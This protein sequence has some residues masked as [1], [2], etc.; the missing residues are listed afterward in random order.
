M[1]MLKRDQVT[2]TGGC[3]GLNKRHMTLLTRQRAAT[4]Y[5][6]IDCRLMLVPKM[7]DQLAALW[8]SGLGDAILYFV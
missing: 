6:A 1:E 8:Q 3:A 2:V 4:G 5:A 7:A